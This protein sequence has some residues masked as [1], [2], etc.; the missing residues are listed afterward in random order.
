MT[1]TLS[2]GGIDDLRLSLLIGEES[3]R[4]DEGKQA[5]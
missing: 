1:E 3:G 2:P 4:A 5:R